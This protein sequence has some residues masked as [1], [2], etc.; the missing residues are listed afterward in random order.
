M[1]EPTSAYLKLPLRTFADAV[2]DRETEIAR[3]RMGYLLKSGDDV[4]LSVETV[5]RRDA[6]ARGL[7]MPAP[8]LD[9][10]LP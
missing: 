6:A 3:K 10:P 9:R 8:A 4:L 7:A 1:T 5:K 2:I